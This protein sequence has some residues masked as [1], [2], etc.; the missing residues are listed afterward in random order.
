MFVM[1]SNSDAIRALREDKFA[2][3]DYNKARAI[4]EYLEE[5]E[6]MYGCEIEFNVVDIR[7]CFCWYFDKE[8]AEEDGLATAE[9][10]EIPLGNRQGTLFYKDGFLNTVKI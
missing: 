10:T 5:L 7:S 1:I 9:W 2:D 4:V 6:S 8:D 3:W